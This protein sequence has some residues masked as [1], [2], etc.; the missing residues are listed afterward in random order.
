MMESFIEGG[1]QPAAPL[2]QL[3]Y[4]KS[5]TDRCISWPDTE[6]LLRVLADAVS[7]RRWN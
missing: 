7:A 1:N 3:V 2:G 6:R 5:I 4:G